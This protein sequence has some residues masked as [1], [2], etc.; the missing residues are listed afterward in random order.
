MK[1]AA[2]DVLLSKKI[3]FCLIAVPALW[4]TYAILLLS[5]S[6]FEVRSIVV[7]LIC[8]PLFSYLGVTW[9]QAGIVGKTIVL[10]KKIMLTLLY[11]F[12]INLF[13]IHS[14]VIFVFVFVP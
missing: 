7:F 11:S 1:L 5:F 14:F 10:P 13:C 2:R 9:V 6:T 4:M 3:V 12:N 8:C